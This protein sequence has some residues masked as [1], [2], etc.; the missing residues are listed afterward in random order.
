MVGFYE[1]K[2]L[3][4]GNIRF[5]VVED[6]CPPRVLGFYGAGEFEGKVEYKPVQ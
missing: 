4:N 5:T 2:R 6:D 3:E 1:V